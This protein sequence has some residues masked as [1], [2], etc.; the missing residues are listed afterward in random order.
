M[1][2]H[3]IEFKEFIKIEYINCF[4]NFVI[5]IYKQWAYVAYIQFLNI[6]KYFI[7]WLIGIQIPTKLCDKYIYIN[8]H[9]I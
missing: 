2:Y 5:Y 1:V 6:F 7:L 3:N 8:E 4:I 9:R